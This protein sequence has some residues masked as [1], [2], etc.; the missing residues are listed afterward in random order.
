MKLFKTILTL[1]AT[2]LFAGSVAAQTSVPNTFAGG[3]TASATEVNANFTALVNAINALDARVDAL[4][5]DPSVTLQDIVGRKYCVIYSGTIS[6]AFTN[7]FARVGSFVGS[8]T[9]DVTSTTQAS[10]TNLDDNEHELGLNVGG[11]NADLQSSL[12]L[13]NDPDPAG[14]V[15]IE[16]LTNGI[17]TIT[18]FGEFMVSSDGN[19]LIQSE[20]SSGAVT[21]GEE[22]ETSFAIAI[23]CD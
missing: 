10:F 23:R 1:S 18:E 8:A 2:A 9:L 20:F 19:I 6:A 16:S 5:A 15:T 12:T 13:Y 21:G 4:E 22:A 14:T 17:L 11:S 3:E 7:N